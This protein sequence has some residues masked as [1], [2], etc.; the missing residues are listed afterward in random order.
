MPVSSL[1]EELLGLA[2]EGG[3]L[4]Q[5]LELCLGGGVINAL[6]GFTPEPGLWL[7]VS[8]NQSLLRDRK[9]PLFLKSTLLSGGEMA[10]GLGGRP[11]REHRGQTGTCLPGPDPK[12]NF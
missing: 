10:L 1:C 11:L 3:G 12:D 5:G 6:G 2:V 9:S 7:F 8:Q 4:D